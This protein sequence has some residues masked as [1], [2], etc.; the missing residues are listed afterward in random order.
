MN[1]TQMHLNML[2]VGGVWGCP[3]GFSIFT[4]TAERACTFLGPL[5][6]TDT[7]PVEV[8]PEVAA[9]ALGG[10]LRTNRRIILVLKRIGFTITDAATGKDIDIDTTWDLGSA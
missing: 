4:K 2:R 1:W 6:D 5:H 8:P 9:E 7:L 10:C 3:A